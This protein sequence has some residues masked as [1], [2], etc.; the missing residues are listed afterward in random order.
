MW[1]GEWW[2]FHVHRPIPNVNKMVPTRYSGPRPRAAPF[3]RMDARMNFE[4]KSAEGNC[5]FCHDSMAC[6]LQG[7]DSAECVPPPDWVAHCPPGSVTGRCSLPRG[8]RVGLSRQPL[9]AAGVV[10]YTDKSELLAS[11]VGTKKQG[12][13]SSS[14]RPILAGSGMT[15]NLN[16]PKL[17]P[18]PRPTLPPA[19]HAAHS[20]DGQATPWTMTPRLPKQPE[21]RFVGE[22]SLLNDHHASAP[23]PALTVEYDWTFPERA[24]QARANAPAFPRSLI[25]IPC[26]AA[27]PVNNWELESVLAELGPDCGAVA[28]VRTFWFDYCDQLRRVST[29][30]SFL[31]LADTLLAILIIRQGAPS[32][33]CRLGEGSHGSVLINACTARANPERPSHRLCLSQSG[34]SHPEKGASPKHHGLLAESA[35]AGQHVLTW[36]PPPRPST[37]LSATQRPV[38]G[39]LWTARWVSSF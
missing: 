26:P 38:L 11:G 24:P 31:D 25:V 14:Q 30:G 8:R 1:G 16:T 10:G 4:C 23:G 5:T 39:R 29:W 13:L 22:T 15:R 18:L 36:L 32:V 28:T 7:L 12:D 9:L 6:Y 21:L 33:C 34:R 3:Q 35:D 37:K 20:Q 19:G 27:K 17:C 2:D